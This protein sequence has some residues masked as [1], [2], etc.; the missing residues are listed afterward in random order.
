MSCPRA[1]RG[2]RRRPARPLAGT[3]IAAPG[4][5]SPRG[6]ASR[7]P[8]GVSRGTSQAPELSLRPRRCARLHARSGQARMGFPQA[9]EALEGPPR[10]VPVPRRPLEAPPEGGARGRH[11]LDRGDEVDGKG[12]LELHVLAERPIERGAVPLI[13]RLGHAPEPTAIAPVAL[14]SGAIVGAGGVGVDGGN[15]HVTVPV[16]GPR[17]ETEPEAPTRILARAQARASSRAGGASARERR[18]EEVPEPP[19]VLRGGAEDGLLRVPAPADEP[20]ASRP[21]QQPAEIESPLEG[22]EEVLHPVHDE[23]RRRAEARRG[24]RKRLRIEGKERREDRS[25]ARGDR[26]ADRVADEADAL[27]GAHRA[28]G[29]LDGADA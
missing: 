8:G 16:R 13:H 21:A 20:H 1:S 22:E 28:V 7:P 6:G 9:E 23:D 19:R 5:R 15:V 2:W 10:E 25:E 29:L 4:S 12:A 27:A 14:A 26:R 17:I 11:A 3:A 24:P 18:V